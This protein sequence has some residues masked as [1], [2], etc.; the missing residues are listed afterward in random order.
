MAGTVGS[1]FTERMRQQLLVSENNNKPWPPSFAV[2]PRRLL[3]GG[4][5]R[6]T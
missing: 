4:L 2:L 1:R 5:S 3:L 6:G